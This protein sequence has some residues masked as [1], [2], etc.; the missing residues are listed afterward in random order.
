VDIHVSCGSR[1]RLP[2]METLEQA[3]AVALM[4]PVGPR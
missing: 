2:P 3:W 4:V 1:F